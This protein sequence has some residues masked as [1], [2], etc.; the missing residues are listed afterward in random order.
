MK[1]ILHIGVSKTGTTTLQRWL[2]QN[3]ATYSRNIC[4]PPDTL[5]PGT[6]QGNHR[7]LPLLAGS[8]LV[9]KTDFALDLL[10]RIS[11]DRNITDQNAIT[12]IVRHHLQHSVEQATALGYDTML[13]SNEHLSDR[14][15]PDDINHF[16]ER[17]SPLFEE[18][19]L[20]IYLRQQDSALLSLYAESLKHG[21]KLNFQDFIAHSQVAKLT[22]DYERII[23]NW[24]ACGWQIVPRL[25]YERAS[26]PA[27][28]SLV[29][30]FISLLNYKVCVDDS[31]GYDY[32]LNQSPHSGDL[33][34]LRKLN[35]LQGKVPNSILFFLKRQTLKLK[36]QK[37]SPKVL[38]ETLFNHPFLAR[39]ALGN[40]WVAK[41]YF[42]RDHL[43]F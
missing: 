33:E 24:S 8:E 22:F 14:L 21:S 42:N 27:G 12:K 9:W 13:L 16:S 29:N 2:S 26:L 6:F 4:Y 7:L 31:N 40:A 36:L 41:T 19:V 15:S 37:R 39:Y 38:D 17:I 5:L 30:D 11:G 32:S 28:W 20:I 10:E 35:H 3:H 43:F 1:L 23:R 25:Y 18:R 34:I